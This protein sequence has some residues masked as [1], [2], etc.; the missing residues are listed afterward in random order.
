MGIPEGPAETIPRRTE[1][2]SAYL[3]R[4]D[5]LYDT[6][7]VS[8]VCISHWRICLHPHGLASLDAVRIPS[9]GT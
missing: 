7:V 3:A 5:T 4:V 2:L 1:E 6:R 9:C 8:L